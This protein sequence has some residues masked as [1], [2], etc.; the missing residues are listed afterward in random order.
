MNRRLKNGLTLSVAGAFCA[1]LIISTY[2]LTE[3]RIR[4]NQQAL[5]EQRLTPALAGLMYDSGVTESA[6]VL[7]PPHDLPG[8]DA[9]VVYRVYAGDE[10]VA[11]L[12]AVTATDGYA[13]PIR[14][15]IGIDLDGQVSGVRILEH[16]ETKGF[17]NAIEHTMSD[18]DQQFKGRSLNNPAMHRWAIR[19][20][21]GEF[22]QLSGASVTPRAVIAAI[23]DTL[24]W[25][26]ANREQ[27][28]AWPETTR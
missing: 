24:I 25:F 2:W 27:V 18:W 22:D 13:G 12:F 17:G 8:E 5:L 21:G 4:E 20:D 28:F 3:P 1:G 19:I 10:P 23:R 15:L 14:V 11:A 7:E 9:A 6:V 16:Q 26:E